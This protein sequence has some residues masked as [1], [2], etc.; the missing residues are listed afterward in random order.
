MI[1][2]ND[3]NLFLINPAGI[4]FGAGA[5]LDLGGGS[6]YGSTSDSILFPDGI[7]F[8]ANEVITPVLTINAPIGLNFRDNP[9]D[10]A[11]N[12]SNLAVSSG[13]S[14]NLLGGEINIAGASLNAFDGTVNLGSIATAG[15]I[16][17]T[18]STLDFGDLSLGDISLSNEATINVNRGASGTINVNASNLTLSERSI[19]NGGINSDTS[20]P[21][22][23]AGN[24]TINLSENLTLESGSLIRN[25]IFPHFK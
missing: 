10:I 24:V 11:V 19:F 15:T 1:R 6:F 18:P 21:D 20:T 3:A 25:N 8:S 23:Q 5:R 17:L 13:Q 2:A 4:L 16:T 7:E 9:A 22:T 12:N 14:L